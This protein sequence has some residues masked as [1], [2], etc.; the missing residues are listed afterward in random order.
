MGHWSRK[1]ETV[2]IASLHEQRADGAHLIEN[3]KALR[4]AEPKRRARQLESRKRGVRLR[5]GRLI[6]EMVG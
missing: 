2:S 6:G 3:R 4:G 1:W 5:D